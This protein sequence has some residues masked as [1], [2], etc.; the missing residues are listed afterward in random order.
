MALP[1]D[2]QEVRFVDIRAIAL[3][4]N[5]ALSGW[6]GLHKNTEFKARSA[7][8]HLRRFDAIYDKYWE[9]QLVPDAQSIFNHDHPLK[10]CLFFEFL[11]GATALLGCMDSFFQETNCAFRL[12][13]SPTKTK[14][15]KEVSLSSVK[16]ELKKQAP[17]TKIFHLLEGLDSAQ[18]NEW[19]RFL[20]RLRNT[21]LHADLYSNSSEIRNLSKILGRLEKRG[22]AGLLKS[23]TDIDREI[24]RDVVFRLDQVNYYMTGLLDKLGART[25][26][27]IE[28]AYGLFDEDLASIVAS[29]K[30][31][32]SSEIGR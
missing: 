28:S 6:V 5:L 29:G 19:F 26:N 2:F 22:V 25:I 16:A 27:W 17:E 24:K 15:R 3:R 12:G 8:Y 14:D 9:V 32:R 30:V 4:H 18:E 13:L 10:E 20:R 21:A 11:A 31:K 1:K 23:K 7:I